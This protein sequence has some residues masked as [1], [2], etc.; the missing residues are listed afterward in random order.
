MF[1]L[2]DASGNP[3]GHIEVMLRWKS[4]YLPPSSS[5]HSP[6]EPTGSKS[7]GADQAKE[8]LPSWQDAG[9]DETQEEQWTK[10]DPVN[11]STPQPDA[12]ASQVI[13]DN[14]SSA[15]RSRLRPSGLHLC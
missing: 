5:I 10:G 1:E 11:A 9:A 13:T 12:D 6:G 4:S 2:V 14:S 8:E 7:E 15:L 3:A